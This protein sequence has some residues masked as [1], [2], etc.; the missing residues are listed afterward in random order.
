[1]YPFDSKIE[2]R[3]YHVYWNS[4]WQNAE[5]SH[6]LKVERETYKLSKSFNP[7]ACAIKI[8]H[9]LFDTWLTVGHFPREIPRH[10]YFFMKEG[11]NI[12][13]DKTEFQTHKVVNF[14]KKSNIDPAFKAKKATGATPKKNQ[15]HNSER[16][17]TPIP[18]TT[19]HRPL[20][21]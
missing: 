19:H 5:P 14:L 4:A 3:E 18:I 7:Y 10:C 6:N 1:M 9:Q 16:F 13:V 12:T 21:T 17:S 2:S 11:S 8:K 20:N 15:L